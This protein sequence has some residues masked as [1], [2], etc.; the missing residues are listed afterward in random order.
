MTPLNISRKINV[1]ILNHFLDKVSSF[2]GINNTKKNNVVL[3]NLNDTG[4]YLNTNKSEVKE[5][6]QTIQNALAESQF[7]LIDMF[8]NK[9]KRK[10]MQR[11]KE[12]MKDLLQENFPFEEIGKNF[13]SLF[14][15]I[16]YSNLPCQNINDTEWL[17]KKCLLYGRE[18]D[19]IDIF[20]PVPTDIGICCSFNHKNILRD[21]EFS[22]L[23]KERQ[24]KS[25]NE[26][27]HLAKIGKTMGLQVFVDQHSN[28]VTAGSISSTS[29]Y[30]IY[31][32][33]LST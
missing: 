18:I 28:R 29:K 3:D 23:I 17:L 30:N 7:P 19:C 11:L 21:S 5:N 2:L 26:N 14:K 8:F 15:L 24:Q 13:P 27:I 10:D 9:T 31:S 32:L 20:K 16:W 22:K 12:I 4:I 25:D 33:S 1:L 6:S